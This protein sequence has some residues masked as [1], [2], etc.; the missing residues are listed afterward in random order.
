MDI[1]EAVFINCPTLGYLTLKIVDILIESETIILNYS[2][3]VLLISQPFTPSW[4]VMIEVFM[5]VVLTTDIT[6]ITTVLIV[7]DNLHSLQSRI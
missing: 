5:S 3:L 6:L 4:E 1:N 2:I 7:F